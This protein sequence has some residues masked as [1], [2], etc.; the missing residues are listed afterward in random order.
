MRL[1]VPLALVLLAALVH[2]AAAAPD[3]H[4]KAALAQLAA[5][6]KAIAGRDR[7][8]FQATLTAD[9]RVA[10]DGGAPSSKP[11]DDE[12]WW[13][14]G[15]YSPEKF[16]VSKSQAAWFG[17]WGLVA[18]EVRITQRGYAEPAGAGDPHP[19]PETNTYHWL[20]VVVAD[21]DGVKTRALQVARVH[22]DKDLIADDED[23]PAAPSGT[24][25]PLVVSPAV[26]LAQLAADPAVAVFGSSEA[27]RGVGA[28]A[29]KKLLVGWKRLDLI[30]IG[31]TREVVDGDL[32]FAFTH[33]G[34]A[35]KGRPHR[36]ELQAFVVAH[37]VGA[38]WQIVGVGFT[39][40]A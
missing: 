23:P 9:A 15:Y 34:L 30:Q 28:A 20:A 18:A 40:A 26:L 19:K 5:Q 4:V 29:A 7:D 8:A 36:T 17:G 1:H 2:T 22:P 24:V 37:K 32:A 12:A 25:A 16:A 39:D 31:D 35:L 27:E 3:P 11:D 38:V 10:W 6:G 33:V 14:D 13:Q 21:G